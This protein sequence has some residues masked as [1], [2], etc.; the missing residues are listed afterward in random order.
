MCVPQ[1]GEGSLA[2]VSHVVID[3][4]HEREMDTDF[5]LILVREMLARLP[6]L[7]IVIMSATVETQLFSS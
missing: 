6:H 3:E 7:R 4:V 5:L 1:G 2:G